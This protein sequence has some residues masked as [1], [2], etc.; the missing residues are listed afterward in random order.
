VQTTSLNCTLNAISTSAEYANVVSL[1]DQSSVAK[2]QATFLYAF[3]GILVFIAIVAY[4]IISLADSPLVQWAVVFI[5]FFFVVSS[6]IYAAT[7]KSSG[8]SPFSKN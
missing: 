4:F 1:L 7:A 2:E 6:I 5:V 3:F 8:H